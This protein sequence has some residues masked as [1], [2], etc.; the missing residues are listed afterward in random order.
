MTISPTVN[1]KS[2]YKLPVRMSDIHNEKE[3]IVAQ[4]LQLPEALRRK[5]MEQLNSL[6]NACFAANVGLDGPLTDEQKERL[7][8]ISHSCLLLIRR[9]CQLSAY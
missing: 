2:Y 4:T 8:R 5:L 6:A 7:E 3:M 9:W 1:H